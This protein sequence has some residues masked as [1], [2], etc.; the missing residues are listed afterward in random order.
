[1]AV[2]FAAGYCQTLILFITLTKGISL[3]LSVIKA[4]V[5]T[6]FV[7]SVDKEQNESNLCP[8]GSN[9]RNNIST[10]KTKMLIFNA[11]N[12]WGIQMAIVS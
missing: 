6:S 4:L 7:P 10:N 12:K 3:G 2:N 5:S 9:K 11:A 8:E 1:M